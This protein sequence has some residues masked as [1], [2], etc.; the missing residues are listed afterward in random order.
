MKVNGVSE[1]ALQVADLK[2]SEEFYTK[3][4]GF[5][6]VDR[7][8]DRGIIWILAGSTAIGLWEKQIGLAGSQGGEHVHFALKI[9][10]PDYE[11]ILEK[12]VSSG[13]APHEHE[14]KNKRGRA[15]Y[16]TDPDGHVVE[17]WTWDVKKYLQ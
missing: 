10:E 11:S 3:K 4:L 2:K 6:V 12:L 17:F 9:D 7:W 5:P 1:L 8:E 15:I 16:V 13:L 14:F